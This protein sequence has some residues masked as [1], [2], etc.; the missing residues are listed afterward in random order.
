MYSTRNAAHLLVRVATLTFLLCIVALPTLAQTNKADIVGT[1][2]DSKGAA[3]Q[4]ATVTITKVD[5]AAA[6]SVTTGDSGEYQAPALDIG[7]YKISATKSGFQTVVQ[8]NIVL[9]TSD[10][11]RI[12]LTLSPGDVT[13]VVTV[14]AAAPLVETETSDRGTVISGRE[15]TELPLS[16][17]N[18]T[19][20]ATLMPGVA[21]SSNTGFGGTGPDAR[22][23]NNGDPRAGDGGPGSSNAQGST[24]NS[25]F[26][27]SGSGAL[28]VNGQR[29]TNN[30]FSLDGVDNNEPQ[31]GT[32]GVFPNPD[33]IAEFKVTTSVPPAEVGRA[34]GA[35]ISTTIKSGTNEFHG[36]G[37]YYGQNSALNAYHPKLKIDRA[38]AISRGVTNLAPFT[39]AVQ[40]IHEYGGTIGGPIIKNKTFFFFDY[41]GQ[42]NH[43]PFP[44]SSTVPTAGSR[45]GNFTG[46]ANHDCDGDGSTT[47]AN[48]GPVC[49]PSTGK[50]FASATIPDALISPISK[51]L[52]NLYPLPTINV[53]DPNQGNNNYFTQRA[54]QER[55]NNYEFKIDHKLSSKNSLTGRYSNQDLKTNRA[56]L[57]PG[58]PTAG[59]GAGDEVGN[60]RQITVSDT[61]SFSPTVLNE[62]RFGITK[63]EIGIFNCGVG[64]ACGTSA[65][66][67]QDI[68]YPN[69]ND[70]SLEAS[71][72]PG[73]GNFGS[74]FTEYLGDGGLFRVKSKNPYFADS[75]TVVHGTHVTK[76]GGEMRLRYLNTIDGGRSGF[77]KG[78]MQYADDGPAFNPLTT[79]Q[80]CPAASIRIVGTVTNCY[81]DANGIPYG[82]TSNAQANELMSLPAF[83]V[84]RGKVF[85]GPFNLRTQEYGFF[86]EDD[87]KASSRLTLNLG[88][89]YDL[90]TAPSETSGRTSYYFP[91]VSKVVVASNSS[92]RIVAADKNNFGPR[93]GFAYSINKEKTMVIRGGYGLLYTLDGTDYP[94]SIRNPPFTNTI[95][96]SQFN[97]QQPTNARTYFSVNTGP[98][99]VTT[100]IDPNNL[101][102]SAALFSVDRKQKT[103][104]VH[105]F[106]ISYQWQFSRDW[107]LDVG[108]VGNR[109][110]N[111]LTTENIG[112]GGT[113][114]A[115]NASGAFL[116]NVLLYTNAASSRYDGLQTQVQK[117]LSRNI[118]GQVSYTFSHT[119][120]NGVGLIGSLGDSRS[121]GRSGYVNPFDIN[122]DNSTS[123]LDVRH[124]LSADAIID[125]PFGKGQKYWNS[126]GAS[127]KIVGGWQLNIIQSARSGFPF[128][129]ICNCDLG[130]PS[131]VGDPF[132]GVAPGRYLNPAAFST[133]AGI[134]VLPANAAGTVIRFGNEK[135]NA[136]RGPAIWNTDLSLFKNTALTERLRMQ[137][138][139][140]F[141]N[142]W[143][144]TKR[145]VP[146][147]DITNG[148]F[149]R[150]DG[151]FPGRVI[152][153]RAKLIF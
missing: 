149:G 104:M 32:I 135:R 82:G 45:N 46:F 103:G 63:I 107:S 69:A 75:V 8:E 33:A 9:Q 20:L 100:Q 7:T 79:G 23:F 109:S 90:F 91:D 108:Y 89:R 52:F 37:Y 97:G 92:D 112:S 127:N 43:L 119:T 10:R 110:R 25:R 131:L 11:L 29:S 70:G 80:V 88:L 14:V 47:G 42:R 132:A 61:H 120:D 128:S 3:V 145:T 5:T 74:G 113:A 101:P 139:I 87:W 15:V 150:F 2:S 136:F 99:A 78:N 84:D 153:Y 129:V 118:Q 57:L 27:R 65:T 24:E 152:Q 72:G 81:V 137:I 64:G 13:G 96:F 41:L 35:V 31:F 130:R 141:F 18:F 134:T 60:T 117:R 93:A 36:S 124:L 126:S 54:N 51:K 6:R 142:F 48:D 147:T 114:A 44:A 105:Q 73:L 143:N 85:G 95:H 76:F 4:G 146:I 28:S 19:Q 98:P 111:L 71:G 1:V 17:R 53:F 49:N 140:E 102:T 106:Q 151:F 67:A 21:A 12:D 58:L 77:L 39:K 22:Q 125:L 34:A 26:A 116:G 55:I 94:P 133:T 40:Q 121:G 30:N 68:G 86:V 16:G 66:F 148:G 38:D 115:K 50:A 62:F 138:G 59:F 122:A 123:S 56:N 144:H 83:Q